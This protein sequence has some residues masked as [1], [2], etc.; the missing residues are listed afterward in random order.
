MVVKGSRRHKIVDPYLW[1]LNPLNTD[2]L[3]IN[4]TFRQQM[5]FFWPFWSQFRPNPQEKCFLA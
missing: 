3:R 2:K 1:H 4:A 5:A